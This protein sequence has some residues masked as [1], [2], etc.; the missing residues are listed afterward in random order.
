MCLL[1]GIGEMIH[2]YANL[3]KLILRLNVVNNIEEAS[4]VWGEALLFQSRQ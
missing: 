1:A 3:L 4:P 2:I